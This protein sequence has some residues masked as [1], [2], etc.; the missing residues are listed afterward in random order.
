MSITNCIRKDTTFRKSQRFFN[1]VQIIDIN[2]L[3]DDDAEMVTAEWIKMLKNYNAN[4]HKL[5][6]Q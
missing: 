1:K 3:S 2:L 5:T 6:S 4:K